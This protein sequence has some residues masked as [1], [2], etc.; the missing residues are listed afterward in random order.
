[1]LEKFQREYPIYE[2][3]QDRVGGRLLHDQCYSSATHYGYGIRMMAK[4]I[5]E[6][7]VNKGE[8]DDSYLYEWGE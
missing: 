4:I 8:L 1:M 5:S 2:F 6:S 3:I 7:G